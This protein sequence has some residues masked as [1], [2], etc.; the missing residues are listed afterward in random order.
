MMG[1]LVGKLFD[2]VGTDIECKNISISVDIVGD[3]IVYQI[4]RIRDTENILF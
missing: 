1:S 2:C 4:V 3:D